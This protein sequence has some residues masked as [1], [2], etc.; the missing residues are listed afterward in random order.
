MV[1]CCYFVIMILSFVSKVY[2]H[3]S[4]VDITLFP[5]IILLLLNVTQLPQQITSTKIVMELSLKD[6]RINLI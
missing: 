1:N 6:H 2:F 4:I 3:L 5:G